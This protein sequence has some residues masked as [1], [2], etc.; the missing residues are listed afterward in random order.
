MDFEFIING[1]LRILVPAAIVASVH[2]SAKT[3]LLTFFKDVEPPVSSYLKVKP[4]LVAILIAVIIGFVAWLLL[5][6]DGGPYDPIDASG[7]MGHMPSRGIDNHVQRMSYAVIF[8]V[9][10][11]VP[12]ATGIIS[13]QKEKQ[14]FINNWY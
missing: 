2:F 5:S 14:Y 3:A 6:T 8:A 11:F 10:A 9:T 7:N 4:Y 12:M 1:I 13:G